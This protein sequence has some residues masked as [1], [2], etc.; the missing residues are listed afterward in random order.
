MPVY[1][2]NYTVTLDETGALNM[3]SGEFFPGI[4]VKTT[5]S[6]SPQDASKQAI[7]A[8][9]SETLR[10]EPEVDLVVYPDEERYA[11]AYKVKV[12]EENPMRDW[13]VFVD[14]ASGEVLDIED[15]SVDLATSHASPKL[16]SASEAATSATSESTRLA[17]VTT[18]TGKAYADDPGVAGPITVSLPRLNGSGYRLEGTYVDVDNEDTAPNDAYSSTATFNYAPSDTR[19]D[20]VNLYYHIDMYAAYLPSINFAGLGRTIEATAHWGVNL[21]DARYDLNGTRDLF[22]GDGDGVVFRDYSKEDDIIYHEFNHAVLHHLGTLYERTEERALHEGTADYLAASYT[23]NPR[24]AQWVT[25]CTSTGDLRRVDNSKSTFRYSNLNNIQY[26]ACSLVFGGYLNGQGSAHANGMIWSG[27]LWD[28]RTQIGKTK[29]DKLVITAF[30][31]LGP[32]PTFLQ[33][34]DAMIQA[35]NNTNAGANVCAIRKAFADRGIGTVCPT[36]PA[37]PTGLVITNASSHGA[38]PSLQWNASAGAT[39]YRIYRCYATGGSCTPTAQIGTNTLTTYIDLNSEV[40]TDCGSLFYGSVHYRVR[41][42][43]AAGTSP[44]SSTTGTCGEGRQRRRDCRGAADG[45][46]FGGEL[47]EPV[48]PDH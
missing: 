39:L 29:T 1:R 9:D 34:R 31:A 16:K 36:P 48:Q 44:Y 2:G 35:D 46:R 37:A 30:L 3:V 27:S 22:F 12:L 20:E 28:L 26:A 6:L 14:A 4:D 23:N 17:M 19:F 15:V 47:P 24:I 42:E 8:S 45:V 43:N 11:L 18:G 5:P 33:A 25:L 38:D 13:L 41:A 7:I 21:N 32:H 40:R 10:S